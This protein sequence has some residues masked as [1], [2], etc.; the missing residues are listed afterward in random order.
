MELKFWTIL[1]KRKKIR[2]MKL[3]LLQGKSLMKFDSFM[4]QKASYKYVIDDLLSKDEENN[5]KYKMK[6]L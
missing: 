2:A 3:K 4:K 5:T 1:L 6:F